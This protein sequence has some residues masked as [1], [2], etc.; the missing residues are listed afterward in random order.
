M[1]VC[2]RHGFLILTKRPERMRAAIDNIYDPADV[3]RLLPNVWLG[4][5]AETQEWADKRIPILLQTPAAV[6]FVSV[7]PMLGPV[8]L[9]PYL[10]GI[11]WVICGAETGPRARPIEETWVY[12]L[13]A[14]CRMAGVPFW[15]KSWGTGKG[16]LLLPHFKECLE[17]PP[18]FR[19]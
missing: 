7:E 12:D 9:E 3:L 19:G 10:H 1:A 13:V 18:V 8:D 6:R 11:D 16:R 14:Q 2:Q 17:R 4:V 5:T 15:F